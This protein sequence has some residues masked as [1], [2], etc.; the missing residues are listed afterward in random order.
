MAQTANISKIRYEEL[1]KNPVFFLKFHREIRYKNNQEFIYSRWDSLDRELNISFYAET[2]ADSELSYALCVL[3]EEKKKVAEESNPSSDTI[4]IKF[5]RVD[6]DS[7][8]DWIY[9]INCF[10]IRSQNREDKYAFM[11]LLWALDKLFWKKET[12][13]SAWR[14]IPKP[15]CSSS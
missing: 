7:V 9:I 14:S 2:F 15:Q 5:H 4:T 10:A 3:E 12:L 1:R 6:P 11:E 13:I 8:H